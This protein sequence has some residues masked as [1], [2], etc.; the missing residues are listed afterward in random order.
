MDP[1]IGRCV[2]YTTNEVKLIQC[3]L[4]LSAL[5]MFRAGFPTHRQE[6]IKLYVQP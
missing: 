6:L 2:F 4:L 1:C 3:F 5:Y